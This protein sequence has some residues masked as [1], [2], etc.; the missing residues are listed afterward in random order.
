M[1]REIQKFDVGLKAFIERD[2]K[3]LVVRESIGGLW[4]MPGGRIDVGEEQTDLHEILLREIR[5]ELGE[6]FRVT[7]GQPFYTWV[8]M[9]TIPKVGQVY[10]TGYRCTYV[11]GAI[12]ISD[13]HT[14]T[15][16]I[17]QDELGML[18]FAPGYKEAAQRYWQ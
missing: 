18:E 10:L 9:W 6:N 16:W 4:E 1:A 3:L 15:R 2:G 5:E 13:E 17:S 11:S 14:E 8:R 12:T 7:I